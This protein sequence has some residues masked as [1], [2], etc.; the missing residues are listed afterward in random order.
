MRAWFQPLVVAMSVATAFG[1]NT[2][3]AADYL[4]DNPQDF[5]QQQKQLQPGDTMILADGDW[6]DFEARFEAKGT[7]DAPITLTAQTPGKVLIKGVSNLRIGGEHLIIKGLVFTEGHSPTSE[8]V[9]F[10]VDKD[11]VSNHVRVTELVIDNFS[12]PDRFES[13]YWVGIYGKHNRLD[14]SHLAGKRNQGVTVAVRLNSE[15]SQ[16]NY[17][18]IDH[19]YFGP[20]PE[21]G[22]NG[23]ETLRIGTSHYSLTSSFTTVENNVFDR[24]NGEVEIISVKSGDN[25]LLNNT[26]IESRGTLTLRHGNNNT[27]SGNVFLGNGVANT[28][29][30]RVINK[31]QEVANNV[32]VGV[33]GYRFG[34]ALTV[35]NGVPDSPINR[36]HQVENANIHHNTFY[37]VSNLQFAAGSDD[38]RSAV[39]VSSKFT[40]NLVVA[41]DATTEFAAFDDV[42]GI[43]FAD[44]LATFKPVK[45]FAQGFTQ[46]EVDA[47][48]KG[49]PAAQ[50]VNRQQVGASADTKAM[51][52][53]E[54]GPSWYAKPAA[55]TEFDSGAS[56]TVTPGQNALFDA[57][58]R[59]AD[60]DVLVLSAGHFNEEK[61]IPVNKTLTIRAAEGEEVVIAPARG[62]LFEI[63][64]GGS[65]AID[66]LTLTGENAPDSAGN[67]LIRTLKWG[68]LKNYRLVVKN[69]TVKALDINHSFDF[70]AAGAR[71]FATS[72]DIQNSTF[73]NITGHV[74]RLNQEQDDL[75]IYN[76]EQLTITGSEFTDIQGALAL[77]YRGGTDESTFGPQVHITDNTLTNVG[78]GKRN[79][80]QASLYFHGVQQAMVKQNNFVSAAPLRVEETVGEP[81]TELSKNSFKQTGQPEVINFLATAGGK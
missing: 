15:Q 54:V 68:M 21:L 63:D 58:E 10:R 43:T 3:M 50:S 22:S 45:P 14:H 77:V 16:Q 59:A 4:V 34:S 33:T 2:V 29:G 40:H 25:K 74:L 78:H 13:D 57:V 39:P 8:V 47:P 23:G 7:A 44:N 70:F 60:G 1:S 61:I 19:N 73:E 76:V 6:K 46:V 49:W 36:Y 11:T 56:H 35:M 26:F 65:L 41:D 30:V 28:G 38:E 53:D 55:Q 51:H 81:T 17:H 20:R 69:T 48:N 24:C 37:N 31:G 12:N 5:R 80:A 66:G 71:S 64:N 9:S 42:S 75:G 79:K 52:K 62:T 18:R 72:I 32:F 27:V 67:T